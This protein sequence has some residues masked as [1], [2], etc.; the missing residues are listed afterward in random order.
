MPAAPR[1]VAVLLLLAAGAL[2]FGPKSVLSDGVN[3]RDNLRNLLDRG[4]LATK[5]FSHVGPTLSA[6]LFLLDR[7]LGTGE[8]LLIQYNLL[9]FAA[10]GVALLA[11]LRPALPPDEVRRF[12]LLLA[13]GSMFPANTLNYFGETF[14]TTAVGVGFALVVVR[15]TA[16]GWPFVVL[17]VVN[18][19]AT[20]VGLALAVAV[21]CWHERR[22]RY[23]L[24]LPLTAGLILLENALSRG[25]PLASG[26]EDDFGVQ[27]VLPY[28]GW[29]GFGYP[30]AFGLLSLV[31]SFGKGLVFFTPGLFLPPPPADDRVRRLTQIWVAFV[32]GLLLVY[33]RWWAWYG[34]LVWGPRMLLF[35]SLP[36]S[37][38]L[39]QLAARPA[40]FGRNLLVLVALL[41]SC[42]VGVSGFAFDT[43]AAARPFVGENYQ[44]E[45]ALWYVPECSVLWLPFVVPVPVHPAGYAYLA[46]GAAA[47]GCL[48]GP[49]A[50][51]LARQAR[52]L[53]RDAVRNRPT[54]RI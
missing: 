46:L 2:A 37:L 41:L 32:V 23:L 15:R 10:G 24:I 5:K 35:A 48:A 36:A 25:S 40:G 33:A 53:L 52:A 30:L 11:L 3:R 42:W 26:Y 8:R 39:A 18:A 9:L 13:F 27:T 49:T 17:G 45:F 19:P 21:H 28:S 4:T 29:S 1:F 34:G 43:A 51:A 12:G 16:W 47:T 7:V 50:V 54:F 31:L 6:P 44:T 22:L 20:A 14:T 38:T